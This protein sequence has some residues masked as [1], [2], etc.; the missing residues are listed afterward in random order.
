MQGSTRRIGNMAGNTPNPIRIR[1]H[2][3]IRIRM[4]VPWGADR[5][6][7]RRVRRRGTKRARGHHTTTTR[8]TTIA[9][10]VPGTA[11]TSPLAKRAQIGSRRRRGVGRIAMMRSVLLFLPFM[12][13]WIVM[14][15]RV[16]PQSESYGRPTASGAEPMQHPHRS[17]LQSSSSASPVQMHTSIGQNPHHQQ[18]QQRQPA[19]QHPASNT[20]TNTNTAAFS[21]F[22][23]GSGTSFSAFSA[24]SALSSLAMDE[25]YVLEK[26]EA[27]RRAEYEV[28]HAEALRRLEQSAPP[29]GGALSASTMA[30]ASS[31]STVANHANP[32]NA[33]EHRR[34]SQ[35]AGVSPASTPFYAGEVGVGVGGSNGGYFGLAT[36]NEREAPLPPRD[37]KS[38]KGSKS[39]KSKSKSMGS[40]SSASSSGSGED[41][42][43]MGGQ[44]SGQGYSHTSPH[45]HSHGTRRRLSGPGGL[46]SA[47][48]MTPSNSASS[49]TTMMSAMTSTQ[50][51]HAVDSGTAHGHTRAHGAWS[52]PYHVPSHS[53]HGHG[54]GYRESHRHGQDHGHHSHHSHHGSSRHPPSPR[55][56]GTESNP[57]SPAGHLSALPHVTYTEYPP[58]PY[59][60]YGHN[61]SHSHSHGYGSHGNN[62]GHTGPIGYSGT[63]PQSAGP[64]PS[65]SPF[66]GPLRR[67]Q[68]AS[69]NV[70][71]TPSRAPSP[72]MDILLPPPMRE[73]GYDQE[74]DREREAETDRNMDRDRETRR[75]RI[76]SPRKAMFHIGSPP[77]TSMS[78]RSR[79]GSSG[80]MEAPFKLS[81]GGTTSNSASN[82]G[83]GNANSLG[84]LGALAHVARAASA[85]S[86]NALLTPQLSS[87]PSSG[88]S[89]PRTSAGTM[90][91]PT[92]GPGASYPYAYGS[93]SLGG[94]R[95]SS[96]PSWLGPT[97][98]TNHNGTTNANAGSTNTYGHSHSNSGGHLA[99][100]VRAAFGMGMTPI[101][102]PRPR[103][104]GSAYLSGGT[105]SGHGRATAGSL[106]APHS[107]PSPAVRHMGSLSG[108]S[109]PPIT[110]A[111]LKGMNAGAVV[112]VAMDGPEDE[113]D[114]DRQGTLPG[115]RTL[116]V[117]SGTSTGSDWR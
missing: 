59:A 26:E 78:S 30:N 92:M 25:L 112:D 85:G 20:N 43:T 35:S 16:F 49:S 2:I 83:H 99:H 62:N 94:S 1:V 90:G 67:L 110:L 69:A 63:G 39:S 76:R 7:N 102:P 24:F 108:R 57:H 86:L 38:N 89:S 61:A 8:A 12:V 91:P 17:P 96:P 72:E 40:F 82:H 42:R 103:P 48:Q 68:I 73:Y 6:R 19:L 60:Q 3:Q 51:P 32:S 22:S 106:T 46:P 66:L 11:A 114:Q 50:E 36:S 18:H 70:S 28:K 97:N 107:P 53:S 33:L 10:T 101:H 31:T 84:S 116:D 47:L 81:S 113:R 95:A 9:T 54:L 34:T 100:S 71:N 80:T 23:G 104:S 109:S 58:N 74:G 37:G 5:I 14:L 75:E 77:K 79:T 111:P 64:T 98:H 115:F 52:H 105:G 13:L 55:S 21:S 44:G 27:A 4:V 45:G 56:A 41:L 29:P 88:A 87:G 93:K 65:T 117:S 15:T